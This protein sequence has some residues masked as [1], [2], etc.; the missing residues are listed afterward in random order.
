MQ[1]S[2]NELVTLCEKAFSGLQRHCGEPN[3]IANMVVDLEMVGLNG[4]QHFVKALTFLQNDSDLP[5]QVDSSSPSQLVA[6]LKGSSILGYLPI[7]LDYAQEQLANKNSIT[8][9]IEHCHNRWLAF[10]VLINLANQGLSVK[11]AWS[12]GSHP[13]HVVY[14]ITPS[15]QLPEIYIADVPTDCLHSLTIEISKSPIQPPQQKEYNQHITSDELNSAKQHAW[16]NGIM[17][18]ESD[19]DKLKQHAKAILVATNEISQLGAGEQV[20]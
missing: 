10:G 6:D 9:S 3:I 7:L 2:H 16:A 8:L 11:A 4:I 20:A 15:N 18:S 17:V 13:Q 19:W 1:V 14:L 12:N 5:P